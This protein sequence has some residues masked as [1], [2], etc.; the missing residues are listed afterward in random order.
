M[1][2][3][4]DSLLGEKFENVKSVHKPCFHLP[5]KTLNSGF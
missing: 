2:F 1:G 5:G 4:G 3:L